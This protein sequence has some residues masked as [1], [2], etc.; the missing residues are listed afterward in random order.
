MPRSG[1][2]GWSCSPTQPQ[3]LC[4]QSLFARYRRTC[5]HPQDV[6]HSPVDIQLRLGAQHTY[7][8]GGLLWGHMDHCPLGHCPASLSLRLQEAPGPVP[9]YRPAE[10]MSQQHLWFVA[11]WL[12][13]SPLRSEA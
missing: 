6:P 3:V 5:S 1:Y 8:I 13:P 2:R 10:A 9:L 11:Q 7:G 12:S 4:R